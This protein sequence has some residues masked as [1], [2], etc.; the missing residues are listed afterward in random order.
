MEH[1]LNYGQFS[2]LY[3]FLDLNRF[4]IWIFLKVNSFEF[5]QFRIGTDFKWNNFEFEQILNWTGF[6]FA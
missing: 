6:E 4:R 3:R 5:E 1:I 2:D